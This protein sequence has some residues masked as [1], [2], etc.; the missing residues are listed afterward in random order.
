VLD[1]SPLFDQLLQGQAPSTNFTING[2]DYKLGYFLADGI[3]PKWAPFVQVQVY[4]HY[5]HDYSS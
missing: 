1:W 4:L 5:S 3:Y 2:H